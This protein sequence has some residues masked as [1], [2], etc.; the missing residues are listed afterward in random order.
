MRHKLIVAI[1]VLAACIAAPAAAAGTAAD[2]LKHLGALNLVVFDT[3]TTNGQEVEGKTFAGT[4]HASNTTNFGIGSHS[5]GAAPSDYHVLDVVHDASGSWRLKSGTSNGGN[6]IVGSVAMIGGNL[7]GS[8]DFNDDNNAVGALVVGGDLNAS[9]NVNSHSV[10]YGGSVAGGINGAVKDASLA[11][12]GAN[13]VQA[14]QLGRLT[15][16]QDDLTALSDTLADIAP[17][18]IITNTASALDYSHAIG[19]YAVFEMTEAAFEDQNSNFDNL[20]AS[21][22]SGYTTIINVL[23]T[24]LTELGNINATSLNQSVIWNFNG[25]TSLSLKGFHGSVLAVNATVSNSSA[26]EGSIVAKNFTLN[27]EIHLGTFAGG[28]FLTPDTDVPEP[29]SWAMLVCG[30]AL[31][32]GA[33]R[34]QRRRAVRFG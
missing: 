5:Q 12:G 14:Y 19:G 15:T 24:T 20:F 6:G 3:L 27:G 16:L 29:A 11:A 26:I 34:G 30:F 2:G 1:S 32:G 13:D 9:M 8:V 25:A 18:A 33:L 17:L 28:D 21:V 4:L 7:G 23:G 22:P 10:T 31:I